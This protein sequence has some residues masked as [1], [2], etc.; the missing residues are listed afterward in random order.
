MGGFFG[1]EDG[2]GVDFGESVGVESIGLFGIL[3]M[4]LFNF[5]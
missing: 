3:W 5:F 1:G 2:V 4:I